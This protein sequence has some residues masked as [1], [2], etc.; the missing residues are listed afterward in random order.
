MPQ[1]SIEKSL[2]R[3]AKELHELNRL[4]KTVAESSKKTTVFDLSHKTDDSLNRPGNESLWQNQE[5]GVID[6][7]R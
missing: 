1:N 5:K 2:E 4:M 7:E 3:I 6:C